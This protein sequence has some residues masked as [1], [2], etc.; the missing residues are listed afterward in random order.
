MP[1][2][3]VE[4]IVIIDE[5]LSPKSAA[6]KAL[7]ALGVTPTTF[8][9]GEGWELDEIKTFDEKGNQE[10]FTVGDLDEE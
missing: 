4:V 6:K 8:A 9:H 7:T 2:Y 10:N 1:G 3:R 5:A